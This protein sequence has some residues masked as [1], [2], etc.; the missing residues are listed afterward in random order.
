MA[1]AGNGPAARRLRILWVKGGKL[2]PVDTGGK[3]RSYHILRHLARRH[4]LVFF[5]YYNDARD[6]QYERDL[7][8]EFPG[9][10]AMASGLRLERRFAKAAHYL[11]TVLSPAPYAV[12]QFT[13]PRVARRVRECLDAGAF[14]IA[15]C[16]FLAASMNFPGSTRVPVVLFQHNVEAALWDRRA[17]H[18]AG[19]DRLV[20]AW[21]ARRM[22]SYEARVL[23]RCEHIVAVSEHDRAQ[24]A[25][26]TPP[27]RISIVPT[28][29]DVA[30]FTRAPT[31]PVVDPRTVVFVGSMDWAPN[32]DGVQ[33]FC[34]EVWPLVTSRVADARFQVVG[35]NPD[36]RVRRLAG[37]SIEIVGGVPRVQDYLHRGC[38]V[39]VPLRVGGGTRLKIY[40][41]MAASKAIVSTRI[42]AEGLDVRDEADVLLRD[43]APSFAEAVVRL[44]TDEQE[45]RRLEDGA[46]R[47]AEQHDWSRTALPF[48]AALRRVVDVGSAHV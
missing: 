45:R 14:D 46:R 6:A 30:A 39:V 42:G 10:I 29:V 12:R 8:A 28:G 48:D 37:S 35:R 36:A 1:S 25:L 24:F 47:L 19:V 15:V 9:C 11:G 31:S 4:E 26:T 44:L 40:E 32:V 16:D 34:D 20:S 23:R 5:S 22:R 33:W 17:G 2:L 43:D 7:R 41:A 27:E 3:I 38:V 13:T 21:E 18:A